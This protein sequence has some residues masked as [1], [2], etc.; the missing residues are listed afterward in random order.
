[1]MGCFLFY[2]Q[3]GNRMEGKLRY[4]LYKGDSVLQPGTHTHTKTQTTTKNLHVKKKQLKKTTNNKKVPHM[5]L[6]SGIS[7]TVYMILNNHFTKNKK[8]VLESL[9]FSENHALPVHSLSSEEN[10][11]GS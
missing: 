9:Q 8:V 4:K 1:M 11:P 2:V 6:Y 7:T 5:L 10:L 3:I